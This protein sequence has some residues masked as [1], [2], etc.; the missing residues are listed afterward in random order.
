MAEARRY[1]IT[2]FGESMLCVSID[3]DGASRVFGVGAEAN[4]VSAAALAGIRTRWIS[5]LGDD[6]AGT[7]LAEELRV[8]GVEVVADRDPSR[9]TALCLKETVG[10]ATRMRYY[11]AGSAVTAFTPADVPAL[12]DTEWLHLSGI[13]LALSPSMRAATL[14]MAMRARAD[15]ARVSFDANY[16]AALWA[17]PAE[18]WD[19]CAEVLALADLVF[20]GDDEAA[21]VL[22]DVP[23]E[24]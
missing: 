1:G 9:Q 4:V 7:V 10:T 15:G 14:A 11:R 21:A 23:S 5:R 17:S 24:D 6:Q 3:P 8:R 16:R 12:D 19:A 22:G 20:I 2:G 13:D 18:F